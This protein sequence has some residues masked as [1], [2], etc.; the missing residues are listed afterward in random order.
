MDTFTI[1]MTLDKTT[2]NTVRFAAEESDAPV[3][4]VY[5][6]KRVLPNPEEPPQRIALTIAAGE[7]S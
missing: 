1:T 4:M 2:Q 6:N 3:T 5:M 7:A